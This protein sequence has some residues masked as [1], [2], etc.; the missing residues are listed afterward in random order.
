MAIFTQGSNKCY[1]IHI[2]RTGG[3][4]VGNLFENTDGI[5]S[6]YNNIGCERM[7]IVETHLHYPLYYEL[8]PD[9]IPYITVVRNPYDKFVSSLK[10]MSN[11]YP[12]DY[13]SKLRDEFDCYNFIFREISE[14]S[15]HNNWFLPQYKFI[16]PNTFVWKYEWGFGDDFK[17]WVKEKTGIE[18]NISNVEYRKINGEHGD[19][20]KTLSLSE[21]SKINIKK[22]YYKDYSKFDY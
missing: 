2:P 1:Y 18:I 17:E 11:L 21:E 6:E 13:D 10:V 7:N 19:R 4:Y 3:R 5:H 14:Y 20:G 8:S 16:T 9:D 15:S 22:F 12:V